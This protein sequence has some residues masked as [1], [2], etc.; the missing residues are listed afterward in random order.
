MVSAE[1]V[2]VE[3]LTTSFVLVGPWD[4]MERT[5]MQAILPL[6][7]PLAWRLADFGRRQMGL[8]PGTPPTHAHLIIGRWRGKPETDASYFWAGPTVVVELDRVMPLTHRR[9]WPLRL[10]CFLA[11]EFCI[12]VRWGARPPACC[13]P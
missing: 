2:S 11:H 7:V 1:R 5:L 4:P 3:P 13:A 9:N 12:C 10:V 6:A 8:R